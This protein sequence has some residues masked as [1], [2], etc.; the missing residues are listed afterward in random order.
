MSESHV[1]S[2]RWSTADVL[3]FG[4]VLTAKV[5]VRFRISVGGKIAILLAKVTRSRFMSNTHIGEGAA[6]EPFLV[7]LIASGKNLGQG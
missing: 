3:L 4:R 2:P 5:G 1:L 7:V 6:E